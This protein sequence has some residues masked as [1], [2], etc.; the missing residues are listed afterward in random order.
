M[1]ST[2]IEPHKNY[3]SYGSYIGYSIIY[4]VAISHL[5]VT[6]YIHGIDI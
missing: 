5:Y 4:S 1:K 6:V 2:K 3:Q